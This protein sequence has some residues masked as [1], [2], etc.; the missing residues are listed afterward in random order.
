MGIDNAYSVQINEAVALLENIAPEFLE[1]Y[2]I[3]NHNIASF[4]EGG[5]LAGDTPALD[6]FLYEKAQF[7][8]TTLEQTALMCKKGLSTAV[9]KLKFSK[10]VTLIGQVATILG[11]SSVIGA[12]GIGEEKMAICAGILAL[13]GS[14]STLLSDYKEALIC[15]K[16]G[17]IHDLYDELVNAQYEVIILSND[18]K[19][20]IKFDKDEKNVSDLISKSN[21]LCRMI[22]KNVMQIIDKWAF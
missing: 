21:T 4:L 20:A 5:L 10:K 12:I 13:I 15:R 9:K 3:Q 22:N 2:K 8:I 16:S 19:S 1:E 17:N 7:M 18:L 6:A 14:I 11:S